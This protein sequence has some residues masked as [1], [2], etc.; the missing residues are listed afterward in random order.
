MSSKKSE[1]E[2][3]SGRP[4]MPGYGIAEEEGGRGLL[5]WSWAA[6]RLTNAHTYWF[7]ST[8]PDGRPHLMPIWGLWLGDVFYFSTGKQSRKARNLEQNPNCVVSMDQAGDQV[9][10][11]GT[12]ELVSDPAVLKQCYDAYK[13]KYEWDI[14][15]MGEPFLAVLP[16]VVFGFIETS[17]DF[18]NTATRW[19]FRQD[20]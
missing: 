5:P 1:R 8:R 7:A 11:E 4:F 10:V 6:E 19:R 3:A 2:P 14:E 13:A 15:S 16:K 12:A 9:I 18:V 20:S 17:D